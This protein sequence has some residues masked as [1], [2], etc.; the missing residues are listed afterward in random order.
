MP[1]TLITYPYIVVRLA[2]EVCNRSGSYRLARLAAKYGPECDLDELLVALSA[3]CPARR[4]KRRVWDVPCA[5]RFPDLTPPVRPPD[6][7]GPLLRP[8]LIKGGK[9]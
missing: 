6:L 4:E 7:P 2:C 3:D 9:R 5:A 1:E 8:R